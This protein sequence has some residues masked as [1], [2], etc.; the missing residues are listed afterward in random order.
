[1][2][3]VFEKSWFLPAVLVVAGLLRVAAGFRP[4]WYDEAVTYWQA[5]DA[6]VMGP[7][8]NFSVLHVWTVFP[9]IGRFEEPWMLRL[10][11]ILMSLASI[12]LFVLAA[13]H[14]MDRNTASI[15][16]LLLAVSPFHV[17][18][19]S[20]LR[21]YAYVLL[22]TSLALYGLLRAAERDAW[23]NWLLYFAGVWIGL[24]AHLYTAFLIIVHGMYLSTHPAGR[25]I[26]KRWLATLGLV[27]VAMTPNILYAVAI[28]PELIPWVEGR[29]G[30]A[31]LGTVYSFVMGLVFLQGWSWLVLVA[32]TVG[33]FGVL[34]LRGILTRDRGWL[35]R[36]FGVVVPS[37]LAIL[38]SFWVRSYNEQTTRYLLFSQPFFLASVAVGLM[39][40]HRSRLRAC[41][42]AGAMLLLVSALLPLYSQWREVGMGNYDIA[43][44]RL[45]T[46]AQPGDIILSGRKAGLP[47]AYYLRDE[48]VRQMI[49]ARPS[50]IPANLPPADRIWFV[51]LGDRSMLD[52][53]GTRKNGLTA[54]RPSAPPGYRLVS[55]ET[56]LG[57]KPLTLALYERWWD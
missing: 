45:R 25:K 43:A 13:R 7:A 22:G 6:T 15:L 26:L 4:L 36:F 41:I 44:A 31:L 29:P 34:F 21:M 3:R 52:F 27:M 37:T 51:S 54:D 10:P 38:P 17:Y 19:S 11:F 33:L 39:S 47:I 18:Y 57:R 28:K 8:K 46:Q 16:A 50:E 35:L 48:M 20:E 49:F 56:V 32:A 1:M 24:A 42:L 2:G 30:V 14:F 40:I 5:A 9:L 55:T 53:V 12:L 23:G